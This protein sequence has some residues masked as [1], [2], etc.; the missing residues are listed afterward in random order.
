MENPI[1]WMIWGYPYFWKQP[2]AWNLHPIAVIKAKF[3]LEIWWIDTQ[4]IMG[5]KEKA[6]LVCICIFV[7]LSNRLHSLKPTAR[8]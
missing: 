5:Q 4:K 3:T 6:N 8:P 1:E 7:W 2:Y